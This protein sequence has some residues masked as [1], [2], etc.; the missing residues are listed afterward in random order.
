MLRVTDPNTFQDDPLRVYRA[1]QLSARFGF[2]IEAQ[3]LALLHAMVERGDLAE[4]SPERVT[5]EWKKLLLRAERPSVGFEL[6]RELGIIVRD[7]PELHALI[8]TEQEPEWH[9]EGDVWIHTMMVL[10]AAAKIIREPQRDFDEEQQLMVMLASLCHDL[11][12]PS[13]TKMGEKHGVPRIR[14]IGHEEAGAEP[15][16]ILLG[17]FNFSSTILHAAIMGAT[18]HLKPGMLNMT[19]EKGLLDETTYTNAVRKLLKRIYPMPWQVLVACSEADYRGRGIPEADK[20]GYS[21]GELFAKTIKKNNLDKEPVKPLLK[22]E[23]VMAYGVPAGTEV[24]RYIQR[25]E[26]ARDEGK[27]K[28]REEALELLK[29][30]LA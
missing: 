20:P 5:D 17:H 28:T 1:V 7:Y 8:G 18:E 11:G 10:D 21:A 23:D 9:P 19:L 29:K 13:T 6:M 22:G 15:T 16:K 26:E 27:V 25:V 14:S 2:T 24:G 30:L 3:T 4:L 12:K